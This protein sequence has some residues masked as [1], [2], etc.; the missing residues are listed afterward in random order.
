[1]QDATEDV[2]VGFTTTVCTLGS[3]LCVMGYGGFRFWR[4]KSGL[5]W[6]A[7]LFPSGRTDGRT[8]DTEDKKTPTQLD[9]HGGY[10][11]RISQSIS[12]KYV[13]NF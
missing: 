3:R 1:V 6:R 5:R 4:E 9:M 2:M 13:P 8:V 10:P 12:K 11:W 7:I